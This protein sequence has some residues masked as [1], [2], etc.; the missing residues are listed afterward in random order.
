MSRPAGDGGRQAGAGREAGDDRATS[1]ED[2]TEGMTPFARAMVEA[3]P[4]LAIG[5]VFAVSVGLFTLIGWWLDGKFGT[6][7]LCLL[8]G[9]F[10]GIGIGFVNFF[11]VVLNRG[12]RRP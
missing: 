11:K 3:G 8:V 2:D 1:P 9:A 6:G 5:W 12:K 10:F 7:R 4:Y